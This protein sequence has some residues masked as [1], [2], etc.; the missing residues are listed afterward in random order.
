[1]IRKD[2]GFKIAHLISL[3]QVGGVE[4]NY[5]QFINFQSKDIPVKHHTILTKKDISPL[6]TGFIQQG[7]ESIHCTKYYKSFRIPRWPSLAR[8]YNRRRIFKSIMPHILVLW[9]RPSGIHF[10]DI[11]NHT[12]VVYYE[13]GAAWFKKDE[14]QMKNLLKGISGIIC[15][16]FAAKR[17]LE[18]KWGIGKN[19][20]F[21]VCLNAIRP[22]C[23]PPSHQTKTLSHDRPLRL[24]SAGRLIS[25]KGIP[26]AIHAV[27]ELKGRGLPCQLL[28]AGTGK[29]FESLKSLT[30]GLEL[31]KEVMFLGLVP[32]MSDFF[33]H[34]DCFICPS[35][36]EPFGNVCAEAMAHGCPVIATRVDGLPE[37]VQDS[38]T[39]F[40]LVPSLP[41]EDYSVF[42]GNIDEIP[43]Y[44]YNPATDRIEAP[45]LLDPKAI[46]DTIEM[47]C[48]NPPMYRQMSSFAMLVAKE[49]FDYKDH[50]LHV[51]KT[52]LHLYSV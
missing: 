48:S 36:R 26:I 11:T 31:E 25:V 29:E 42:G 2:T 3:S 23:L 35:I 40:C 20:E 22:D 5:S 32:D 52:L 10:S 8:S 6:L 17:M 7:S 19:T 1:M 30:W 50:A 47:L 4:R 14:V 43:P 38:E 46:A 21:R 12:K 37:V 51:L 44:V 9:N 18:L 24:G 16:S 27:S 41:M 39:G 15:N 13:H 49:K 34:I 45:K 33:S 28:V